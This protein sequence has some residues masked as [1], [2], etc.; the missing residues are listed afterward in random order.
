MYEPKLV[1]VI[2]G[3][4]RDKGYE[5]ATEI[6]NIDIIAIKGNE[7]W[8][9]E[10]KGTWKDSRGRALV[11][12]VGQAIR[13]M[14]KLG[15]DT[16]YAIAVTKELFDYFHWWGVEGL[17]LLPIHLFLVDENGNVEHET[18]KGFVKLIESLKMEE[19]HGLRIT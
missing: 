11:E 6:G 8:V 18:P 7:K 12:L 4:F 19:Y 16:Y 13:N 14:A 17:R 2:V 9:I 3:Y 10:A 5:V 15:V 1:G